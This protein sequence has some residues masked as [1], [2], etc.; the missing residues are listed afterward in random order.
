MAVKT[1]DP[2]QVSVIIGSQP[3]KGFSDGDF[4]TVERN[5]DNWTLM[6]GA[7]G[8]STRSKNANKSGKI[9]ITL[10]GSSESNDYLSQLQLAD[11]LTGNGTFGGLIK[12]NRGRSLYT[13]A[14]GWITKQ[15][16]AG[17][18]KESPTREWVIET[19]ELIPF[20]GG[21]F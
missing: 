19:D 15:P 7:D 16:S 2:K 1:Y 21:N 14:T 20:T 8:E 3:M 17:F 13:F 18:A 11:E 6:V 12:D 5:E 9:T 4:V 10:L